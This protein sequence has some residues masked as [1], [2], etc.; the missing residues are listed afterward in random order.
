MSSSSTSLILSFIGVNVSADTV[1]NILKNVHI[2]DNPNV[3]RIGIDDVAVRKGMKYATAIYDLDT[4]HLIALIEGREKDDIVPWL[5][6]HKNI[7]FVAR[8]RASSYADAINE[9]LPNTVQVADR[10]QSIWKYN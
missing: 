9:V 10:F 2:I 5:K 6:E 4:H 7:K 8:D 1:D 3:E